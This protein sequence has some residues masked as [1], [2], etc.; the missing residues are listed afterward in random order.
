MPSKF[1]AIIPKKP[2]FK[3]LEKELRIGLE[4]TADQME[5]LY[6]QGVEDW[7]EQP[8]FDK[9][10]E[11][12]RDKGVARVTTEDEIYGYVHDGTDPHDIEPV[13]SPVLVFSADYSP[14]TQPGRIFSTPGGP[15]GD[16]VFAAAVEHPGSD[17]RNFTGPI[18]QKM[19]PIFRE[20]IEEAFK[21]GAPKTGHKI[22]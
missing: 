15:S 20:E 1:K 6:R 11:L 16:T 14:K 4:N 17:A 5:E 22:S 2:N 3:A 8:E 13:F 18:K 7:D 21:R 10:V 12:E 9:T 19:R